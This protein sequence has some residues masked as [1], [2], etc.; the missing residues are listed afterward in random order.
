MSDRL[1]A[2]LYDT[3]RVRCVRCGMEADALR[4]LCTP[5]KEAITVPDEPPPDADFETYVRW[6]LAYDLQKRMD[7]AI[8][9]YIL[10]PKETP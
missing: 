3:P 6:R 4:V 7:E 8:E 10:G 9:E 5:C 2:E 1:D